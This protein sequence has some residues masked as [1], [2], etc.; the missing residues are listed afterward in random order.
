MGV[1]AAPHGCASGSSERTGDHTTTMVLCTSEEPQSSPA[2]LVVGA[3][4]H[5]GASLVEAT[6]SGAVLVSENEAG[7]PSTAPR[8]VHAVRFARRVMVADGDSVALLAIQPDTPVK[9]GSVLRS[10]RDGGGGT[11]NLQLPLDDAVALSQCLDVSASEFPPELL[12]VLL[13]SS[14]A[15]ELRSRAD[16]ARAAQ[17]DAALTAAQRAW[18]SLVC[19]DAPV[20]LVKGIVKQLRGHSGPAAQALALACLQ[21]G[22]PVDDGSQA[23]SV[24]G[25]PPAMVLEANRIA[26]FGPWLASQTQDGIDVDAKPGA[27]G[28]RLRGTGA[29][30]LAYAARVGVS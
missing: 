11:V 22:L 19:V 20:D 26:T 8:R 29:V 2:V 14:F 24:A 1:A 18:R 21:A 23:K 6:A 9:L 10:S 25:N 15:P 4:S 3:P 28:D 12:S 27:N 7:A 30:P 5:G 17:S 13:A 16:A